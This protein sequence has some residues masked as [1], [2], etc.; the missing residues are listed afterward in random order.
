MP[1]YRIVTNVH[2]CYDYV[3]S[4]ED[5]SLHIYAGNVCTVYILIFGIVFFFLI[6]QIP[7]IWGIF[8]FFQKNC[9]PTQFSVIAALFSK[10][11]CNGS[12]SLINDVAN[13]EM[14]N[15]NFF[16]QDVEKLELNL[17]CFPHSVYIYTVL[18][19]EG[20][21]RGFSVVLPCFCLN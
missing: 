11:F 16:L 12:A 19:T 15:I 18:Y 1:R 17:S 9:L 13:S 6:F 7:M 10:Y 4:I 21:N 3:F 2:Q 14:I 20:K 5:F 8:P